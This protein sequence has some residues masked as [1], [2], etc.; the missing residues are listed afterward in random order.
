LLTFVRLCFLFLSAG[1]GETIDW[2][3]PPPERPVALKR[4]NFKTY[5]CNFLL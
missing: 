2:D 5:F 4:A 1:T 3:A